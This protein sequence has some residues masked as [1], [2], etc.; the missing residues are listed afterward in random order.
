MESIG[1]SKICKTYTSSSTSR[2]DYEDKSTQHT[3]DIVLNHITPFSFF[4][5]T[6]KIVQSTSFLASDGS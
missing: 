1:C 3:D 5:H 4:E 6:K 2:E